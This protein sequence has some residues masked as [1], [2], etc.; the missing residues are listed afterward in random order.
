MM[1]LR[2]ARAGSKKRPVY[3]LVAADR[4][5]RRDGRHVENLGYFVPANDTMVLN[6]ERIDYWLEQGAQPSDTAD[7]LIR[8]AKKFGNK[9]PE[10]KPAYEPKPVKPVEP[11]KPETKAAAEPAEGGAQEKT[12]AAT[13]AASSDAS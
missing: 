7:K 10:A 3:H 1:M 2:L 13:P 6:Q 9:T 11:K 5:A 12:E 8:K 4:R